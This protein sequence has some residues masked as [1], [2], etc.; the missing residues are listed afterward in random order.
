MSSNPI[1]Q[2]DSVSKSFVLKGSGGGLFKKRTK[3][4]HHALKNISLTVQPGE[5]VGLVGLNG[6]GKTT[7]SRIITGITSPT[8]GTVKVNGTVGM[9]AARTGLNNVLTGRENIYYKCVRLGVSMDDIRRME[10][11]IIAF[12]E[13]EDFIDQ[14]LKRYSSGM[15]SR[16]GFAICAHTNPDILIVDEALA[17]GD[18][19]YMDK[20]MQWINDFKAQGHCVI[21]VSHTV[22]QMKKLCDRILWLHKG[23][24]IGVGTPTEILPSY[25][26]F[27]KEYNLIK[28]DPNAST[29]NLRAYQ[30]R[31]DRKQQQAREAQEQE[32]EEANA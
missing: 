6:S 21:Y 24:C 22:S 11:S 4:V 31:I 16:L 30:R 5:V 15:I 2:C 1:I 26:A 9:L 29:P 8:T 19:S 20:C 25:T 7:L 13:L 27:A 32:S 10:E 28:N 23:N 18:Q 14:P 17:V 3:K 12:A